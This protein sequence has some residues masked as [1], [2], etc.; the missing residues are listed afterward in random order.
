MSTTQKPEL[1]F[2]EA[3]EVGSGLFI[4]HDEIST[5]V[6]EGKVG[7]SLWSVTVAREMVAKY[8]NCHIVPANINNNLN[9]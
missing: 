6:K 9:S 7:A 5:I 2:I 3:N 1:Y 4:H 8:G